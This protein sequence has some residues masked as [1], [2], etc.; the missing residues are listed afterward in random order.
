MISSAWIKRW[1]NFAYK[2][3]E[4][5]YLTKGYPLPGNIDNKVLIEEGVECSGSTNKV[6][7]SRC[8]I[9]NFGGS[10]HFAERKDK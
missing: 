1:I 4:Y 10:E 8:Q 6:A 2:K 9:E 7:Y 3:G 5:A